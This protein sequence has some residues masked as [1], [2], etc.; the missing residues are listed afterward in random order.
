MGRE[1]TAPD[2]NIPTISTTLPEYREFIDELRKKITDLVGESSKQTTYTL[3]QLIDDLKI[4]LTPEVM[5][6]FRIYEHDQSHVKIR[7]VNGQPMLYQ[8]GL[9]AQKRHVTD[10]L[11]NILFNESVQHFPHVIRG[12]GEFTGVAELPELSWEYSLVATSVSIAG[13]EE[14]LSRNRVVTTGKISPQLYE[15]TT[16]L[17]FVGGER[18]VVERFA[19]TVIRDREVMQNKGRYTRRSLTQGDQVVLDSTRHN[20]TA[21]NFLDFIYKCCS[22]LRKTDFETGLELHERLKTAGD[23]VVRGNPTRPGQSQSY[24]MSITR[25]MARYVAGGDP[26]YDLFAGRD[27]ADFRLLE[28]IMG[29][30][31]YKLNPSPRAWTGR[32]HAHDFAN[33]GGAHH[34]MVGQ[35]PKPLPEKPELRAEEIKYRKFIRE[36]AKGIVN[37]TTE[38]ARKQSMPPHMEFLIPV[39]CVA[40]DGTEFEIVKARQ[41][42][43]PSG[44]R[45]SQ[46]R[47]GISH[48][49]YKAALIKYMLIK[50]TD[51]VQKKAMPTL[52]LYAFFSGLVPGWPGLLEPDLVPLAQ[53]V[54]NAGVA[55]LSAKLRK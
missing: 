28:P 55:Q 1:K 36:V 41:F 37:E 6:Q 17:K 16:A 13:I 44:F 22:D 46:T 38:R 40:E 39:K 52:A 45:A 23:T 51:D 21:T 49:D 47:E 11:E 3:N 20:W 19:Q 42:W 26:V 9:H 34:Y 29:R 53:Q 8:A 43:T 4:I 32:I 27:I 35:S 15:Y 10:T 31:L 12:L 54:Y 2:P 18:D 14:L 25:K 24:S 48:I 5:E 30:Y 33:S 50:D 7:S